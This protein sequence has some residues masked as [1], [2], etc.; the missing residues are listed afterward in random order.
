[1]ADWISLRMRCEDAC[2]Y[3]REMLIEGRK[4]IEKNI[5]D[6][7]EKSDKIRQEVST[8]DCGNQGKLKLTL[9]RLYRYKGSNSKRKVNSKLR[10]KVVLLL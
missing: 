2:R 8:S 10:L 9:S 7:Q 3:K 1:M 4:R 6:T 5:K